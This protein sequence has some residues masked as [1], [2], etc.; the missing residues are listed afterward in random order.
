MAVVFSTSGRVRAL[1]GIALGVAAASCGASTA[2]LPDARDA[3]WAEERWPGTTVADL[4][5]G[6]SVFVTRCSSCHGLPD[7]SG[8]TAA[9]WGPLVDKMADRAHLTP[10]ERNDVVH[11]LSAVS[12]RPAAT[13]T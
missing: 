9:E 3:H 6:R 12:A 1:A 4:Q 5:H 7:P 11:Y 13:G 2:V 8:S 10:E